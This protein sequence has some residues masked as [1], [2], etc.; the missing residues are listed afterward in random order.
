MLEDTFVEIASEGSEVRGVV[1]IGHGTTG[2]VLS[3]TEE[4]YLWTVEGLVNLVCE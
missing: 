2:A 4:K 1:N 3:R